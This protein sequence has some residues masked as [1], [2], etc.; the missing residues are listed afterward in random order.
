[1]AEYTKSEKKQHPDDDVAR[2]Q[3]TDVPTG[4]T[5]PGGSGTPTGMPGTFENTGICE[6]E[7]ITKKL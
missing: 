1:M 4:E 5:D 6:E 2:D 3:G 7:G